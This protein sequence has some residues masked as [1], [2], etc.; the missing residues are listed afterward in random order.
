M[1]KKES[2]FAEIIRRRV[3]NYHKEQKIEKTEEQN[4]QVILERQKYWKDFFERN[5]IIGP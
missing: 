2:V 5:G 1:E 4:K 3:F